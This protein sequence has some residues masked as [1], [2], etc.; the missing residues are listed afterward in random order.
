MPTFTVGGTTVAAGS[1]AAY[2]TMNTGAN[3]RA[4][5]REIGF[6]TTAATSS[7]VGLGTPANTPVATTTVTPNACHQRP[8]EESGNMDRVL[9]HRL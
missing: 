1:A 5:L 3:R 8:V 9:G 6:F 4:F 2:C 7:S